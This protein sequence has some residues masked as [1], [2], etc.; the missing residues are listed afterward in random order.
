MNNWLFRGIVVVALAACSSK[1]GGSLTKANVDNFREHLDMGLSYE[2][3]VKKAT[4]ELGKPTTADAKKTTWVGKEGDRC[5]TF[6][7]E[8]YSGKAA[9]GVDDADCPK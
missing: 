3:A 8:N 6:F 9:N 7:L 5:F 1:G 2:D 4:E